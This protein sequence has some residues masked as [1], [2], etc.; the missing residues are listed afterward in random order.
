[1]L[2]GMAWAGAAVT[3]GKAGV[4]RVIEQG[5]TCGTARHGP[6]PL[7][8]L[9]HLVAA[10]E[11]ALIPN[12]AAL[13]RTAE[14]ALGREEAKATA[15]LGRPALLAAV[16]V[17]WALASVRRD[18]ALQELQALLVARV[19]LVWAKAAVLAPGAAEVILA[20]VVTALVQVANTDGTPRT[21]RE[22]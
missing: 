6:A 5:A 8:G 21:A 19:A 10:R 2:G 11:A 14:P 13:L 20:A 1:M 15:L 18:A 17:Q 9:S 12:L 22:P 4:L 16:E 7:L 3:A